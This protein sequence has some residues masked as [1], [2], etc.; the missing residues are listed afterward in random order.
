MTSPAQPPPP[1][2]DWALFLDV[3]GTLLDIAETPDGVR[4]RSETVPLLARLRGVLDGAVALV[5]GRSLECLDEMFTPLRLPAAGLHGVER[6]RADGTVTRGAAFRDGLNGARRTLREFG[7]SCPGS[8]IED[9]GSAIAVHYRLAPECEAEARRVVYALLAD[10]GEDY[11]V[12]EG[13]MVVELKPGSAGKDTAVAAFLREPPFLS[14]RPVFVGDDLT[15]EDGFAEVNRR[16][17]LSIRVGDHDT[18]EALYRLSSVSQVHRWLA[19]VVHHLE[20]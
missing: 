5:S 15:D 9:K 4:V 3:D 6:R 1:E 20:G 17:G 13:K 18:S 16:G 8:I 2:P 7:E 19:E 10:L 12:Q 11:R 14:R